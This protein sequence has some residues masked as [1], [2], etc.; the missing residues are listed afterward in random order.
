MALTV[1]KRVKFKSGHSTYLVGDGDVQKSSIGPSYHV[2]V[3]ARC[4]ACAATR[5]YHLEFN[6]AKR[7]LSTDPRLP[8]RVHTWLTRHVRDIVYA[9]A[10]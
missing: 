5:T 10:N 9:R 1:K 3:Y 7:V 6:T 2:T 4:D 8:K